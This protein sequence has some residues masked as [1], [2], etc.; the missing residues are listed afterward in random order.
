MMVLTVIGVLLAGYLLFVHFQW[1]LR[2]WQIW[3]ALTV[4]FCLLFSGGHMWNQI[5]EP[6]YVGAGRNGAPEW[7]AGGFSQQYQVETQI[8]AALCTII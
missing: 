4:S 1:L 8:V 7:I 6:P 3:M 5:R 2:S